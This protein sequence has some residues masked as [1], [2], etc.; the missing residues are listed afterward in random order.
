MAP[1]T[2]MTSD[3]VHAAMNP[4]MVAAVRLPSCS[5]RARVGMS[6][7]L[8]G[9]AMPPTCPRRVVIIA[10]LKDIFSM[11]DMAHCHLS[12]SDRMLHGIRAKQS[13]RKYQLVV[14]FDENCSNRVVYSLYVAS[15]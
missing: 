1:M 3:R 2:I 9:V 5:E 11:C 10:F 4:I 15:L 8:L 7:S 13:I 12:D 6:P 14:K